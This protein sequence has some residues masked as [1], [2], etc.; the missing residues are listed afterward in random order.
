MLKAHNEREEIDF[1]LDYLLS[2]STSER[3]QLMAR[4]S[5]EVIHLLDQH[6]HRKPAENIKRQ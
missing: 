3:F 2:L 6:G 1:E 5:M 4:K